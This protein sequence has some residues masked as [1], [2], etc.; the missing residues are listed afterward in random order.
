MF[1]RTYAVR[2][3]MKIRMCARFGHVGTR[4]VFETLSGVMAFYC[5]RCGEC[6]QANVQPRAAREG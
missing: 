1:G 2:M 4:T 5:P 3:A 6:I